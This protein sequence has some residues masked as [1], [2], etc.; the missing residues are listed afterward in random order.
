MK[1]GGINLALLSQLTLL[2][3]SRVT[4]DGATI[5]NRLVMLNPLVSGNSLLPKKNISKEKFTLHSGK[6]NVTARMVRS[7][8][9]VFS[10]YFL[11]FLPWSY[12]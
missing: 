1:R 10:C 6:S 8:R 3:W 4:C 11:C 12:V 9:M 7:K 2:E 5:R